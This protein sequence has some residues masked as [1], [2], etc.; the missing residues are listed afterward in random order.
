[1]RSVICM[2]LDMFQFYDVPTCNWHAIGLGN[3]ELERS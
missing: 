2:Y 1:M 3:P